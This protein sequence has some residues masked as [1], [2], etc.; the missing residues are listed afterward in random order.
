MHST[1]TLKNGKWNS[2]LMHGNKRISSTLLIDLLLEDISLIT[3]TGHTSDFG[4]IC[5]AVFFAIS[6]SRSAKSLDSKEL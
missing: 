4:S 6:A 1:T 5:N 2:G 3:L